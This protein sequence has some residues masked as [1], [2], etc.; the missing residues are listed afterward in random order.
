[1]S[2]DHGHSHTH[3]GAGGKRLGWTIAFNVVI[4]AAE[5]VGG[6]LTGYLAL[7]ADAVHN[8]SDVAALILAWV[9]VKGAQRPASKRSTYGWQRLE[10]ITALISATALIVVAVFIVVEAYQRLVEPQPINRPGVFMTIAVI[11]L[12]GN[13]LSVWLLE[14]ERSRSLNMK[15]A[16]L[17]ML[18]DA[19][20]S[21]AVIAGG[22]L[23]IFKGWYIVDPILSLLIAVI[24]LVSTY[25]VIREAVLILMEA[26]P[27]RIDFDEVHE[28][29]AEL[30]GVCNVHHLHIWSLSSTEVALSCHVGVAE[31]SPVDNS[32][33]IGR[34]DH[35]LDK[36][37]DIGHTTIQVEPAGLHSDDP[38]CRGRRKGDHG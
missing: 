6:L 2:M 5:V 36:R 16:F 27:E 34:V 33:V 14:A 15:T 35:M 11:G 30:E 25:R 32:A 31:D 28:A 18:F 21:I 3:A 1:M 24:I 23:I 26:V 10:V 22:L 9:G 17:H 37:F 7:L 12:L 13:V 4:T 8:F 29:I 19:V 38:V 20:S